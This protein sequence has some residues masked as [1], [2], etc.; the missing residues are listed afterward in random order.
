M[1][2]IVDS[3][4]QMGILEGAAASAGL[5]RR[6]MYRNGMALTGQS[7]RAGQTGQSGADD[8]NR[9]CAGMSG[10]ASVVTDT[11]Y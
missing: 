6:F 11:N 5:P 10:R 1:I 2:A 3:A 7:H 4:A 9:Y 8:D